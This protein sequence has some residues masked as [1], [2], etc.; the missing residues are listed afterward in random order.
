MYFVQVRYRKQCSKLNS[1]NKRISIK[2]SE[3][4]GAVYLMQ[5]LNLRGLDSQS[6][7]Q[8]SRKYTNTNKARIP[9]STLPKQHCF[10]GI[11]LW[12]PSVG[13][14]PA[15]IPNPLNVKNMENSS[16]S[17]ASLF[18]YLISLNH[19]VQNT[20]FQAIQKT[21]KH[22]LPK[23]F[24]QKLWKTMEQGALQKNIMIYNHLES[25]EYLVVKMKYVLLQIF[26]VSSNV[27]NAKNFQIYQIKVL[28][29]CLFVS[30]IFFH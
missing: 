5:Q 24:F 19:N 6:K 12:S 22:L 16:T 7:P 3:P 20:P 11:S 23:G 15:Q 18:N 30:V 10:G 13:Q 4:F 1:K 28:F 2:Q 9:V 27:I 17:K 14:H 25:R 29:V 21:S 8:H 26:F